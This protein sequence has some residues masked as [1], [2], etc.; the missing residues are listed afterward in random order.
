M[1]PASDTFGPPG[2][3]ALKAQK[4]KENM[5]QSAVLAANQSDDNTGKTLRPGL[6]IARFI[7]H[8]TLPDN[9]V[10]E[11]GSAIQ[12]TWR[13]RN[14]SDEPWPEQ[15]QLICVG[16]DSSLLANQAVSVRGGI[17]PGTETDISIN[18]SAPLSSGSHQMF[19][20]LCDATTGK[21][22]GQRLWIK[23]TVNSSSSSSA[24]EHDGFVDLNSR[25]GN[26]QK[27]SA[28]FADNL[29]AAMQQLQDM[30]FIYE[31]VNKRVLTRFRGNVERAVNHLTK[32]PPKDKANKEAAEAQPMEQ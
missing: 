31:D 15:C 9:E 17:Q 30:G 11:A 7:R 6:S 13:L 14:D 12:K 32:Y 19:W 1:G 27:L 20:R 22:F 24:E 10:V 29:T 16:G 3:F 2:R 28:P 25:M 23:I 18:L 8:V 26:A 21:R 5:S 4:L